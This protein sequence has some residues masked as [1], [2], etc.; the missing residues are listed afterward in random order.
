MK[1]NY[2]ID[3]ARGISIF[4]V[5]LGHLVVGGTKTFNWIFSFHMPIFFLLSG[6]CFNFEKYNSFIDFL[7]EK[8]KKRII[9]YFAFIIIV[10]S[11]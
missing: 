11:H 6:M 5:V 8:F 3:V 10:K 9:P 4:F 7:K 1:R 2:A